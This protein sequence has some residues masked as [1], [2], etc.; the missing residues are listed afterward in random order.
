MW[1]GRI[2][3]VRATEL[4]FDFGQGAGH[5]RLRGRHAGT[6]ESWDRRFGYVGGSNYDE[7]THIALVGK[8]DLKLKMR[9]PERKECA[10]D[11][12]WCAIPDIVVLGTRVSR[13]LVKGKEAW[14][15]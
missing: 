12:V 7:I 13:C 10:R 4:A 3:S 9:Y 14:W 1:R 15:R 2:E 8:D 5:Y 6:D 11:D